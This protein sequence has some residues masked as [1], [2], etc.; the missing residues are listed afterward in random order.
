MHVSIIVVNYNSAKDTNECLESLSQV[1]SAIPYQIVV[2]DNG[3]LE[4]YT[5]PKKVSKLPLSLIRSDSNLGFTG[6]NN[7]GTYYAIENWNSDFLVY[8]NNDTIVEPD[9]LDHL[10]AAASE[11][12]VGIVCPHIFFYPGN[13]FH[14][15][16]YTPDERGKVFWYAGGFIDW[17]NLISGHIGVDEVD[18]GQFDRE[19][20]TEFATG[21]CMLVKREVIETVRPF[22]KRYFLYFEDTDLSQ[23]AIEAGFSIQVCPAS[24]I[25]HKNAGSSDGPGSP[26]QQYYLTRNR[27]LF[28]ISHG[29]L[30][31]RLRTI[32]LAFRLF[33]YGSATERRAVWHW[34]SFRFGKQPLVGIA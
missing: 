2:V 29:S 28:F 8:L 19:T 18:H 7:L 23:R 6:G 27:L 33:L 9:F 30:M 4:S 24:K 25:W 1:T 26:L 14:A 15:K 32:R 34:L 5:L 22:D 10:V 12:R 20:F 13:E 31:T 3:S 11:A 17:R 16:S 21:C